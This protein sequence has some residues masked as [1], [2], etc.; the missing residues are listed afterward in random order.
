MTTFVL[1]LTL[2]TGYG[3]AINSVNGFE[4]DAACQAAGQQW[5]QSAKSTM[6]PKVSFVCV[7]Q[8]K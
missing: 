4:S 6:G 7:E 1:I 2:M 5:A 8:K 3:S